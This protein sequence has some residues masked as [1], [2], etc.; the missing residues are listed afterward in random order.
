MR[1]VG[2]THFRGIQN[3]QVPDLGPM[4]VITGAPGS[5]KSTVLDAMLLAY[6]P[7]RAAC[8]VIP[9]SQPEVSRATQTTLEVYEVLRRTT[10]R[11]V[12]ITVEGDTYHATT[13]GLPNRLV[14]QDN[15]TARRW[16]LIDSDLPRPLAV[17]FSEAVR[18]GRKPLIL[19]FLRGVLADDTA[20]LEVHPEPNG[21][22]SLHLVSGGQQVPVAMA[23]S[24][25]QSAL[26][27]ATMLAA[28][29]VALAAIE[30]PD[31]QLRPHAQRLTARAL[32]GAVRR[33][34]QVVVT[35]RSLDFIHRIEDEAGD[36]LPTLVLQ[37]LT[38]DNGTLSATR[39]VGTD[40]PFARQ[41]LAAGL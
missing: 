11:H 12:R 35:T 34:I 20:E 40:V 7:V 16:V 27:M 13:A 14:Q 23:E 28:N 31:L 24:A 33:G 4:T 2:I 36:A 3:G 17:A 21:G 8:S 25:V 41:L 10:R 39:F 19:D 32:W 1:G 38:L 37:H 5:G 29:D 26:R 15:A 30:T 6:D 18:G 9:R 22:E